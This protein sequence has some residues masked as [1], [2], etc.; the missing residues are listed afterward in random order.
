M[1][2]VLILVLNWKEASLTISCLR[3]LNELI[4][5]RFD[6]LVVDNNSDDHSVEKINNFI[7]TGG[8]QNIS[9]IENSANLG[10]AAGNN[11]GIKH[12]IEKKYKFIW[13]LN[14]DVEVKKNS[15]FNSIKKVKKGFDV[16]GSKILYFDDNKVWAAGGGKLN[17]FF[18]TSKNVHHGLNA[19]NKL[20][21]DEEFV[22][23]HI[24]YLAGAAMLFKT[25]SF[26]K[27]GLLSEDYF[28]YF[29]EPDWFTRAKYKDV[30]VGYCS[31]SI[32]YHHVGA[33]TDNFNKFT[34]RQHAFKK[35][36]IKN[37]IKFT[38]KFYKMRLP[39]VL[40]S[41]VFIEMMNIMSYLIRKLRL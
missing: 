41:I 37:K 5:V 35:L 1:D 17:K 34:K 2:K 28:L 39:I 4:N 6:I 40:I 20:T 32:I 18:M 14:N 25:S 3:S 10:Y 29:E 11:I 15:L 27:V 30:R 38:Y 19:D 9:I 13:L 23:N 8:F 36:I 21:E 33:S 24:D 16:V 26:E 31:N 12:G 7:L 22:E